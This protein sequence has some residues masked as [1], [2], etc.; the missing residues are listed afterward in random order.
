MIILHLTRI[1]ILCTVAKCLI[2]SVKESKTA[3]LSE[4]SDGRK[5]HKTRTKILNN[6][7][8]TRI[9]K[10]TQNVNRKAYQ[11]DEMENT[12]TQTHA[13][14]RSRLIMK[15]EI[16]IFLFFLFFLRC[17]RSTRCCCC[18]CCCCCHQIEYFVE[19]FF[20]S[21]SRCCGRVYAHFCLHLRQQYYIIFVSLLFVMCLLRSTHHN[22]SQSHKATRSQ[23]TQKKMLQNVCNI[24]DI[25]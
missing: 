16:S 17:S 20:H 25:N 24:P 13:P 22:K 3:Q 2:V 4:S 11:I 12:R 5:K 9:R 15:R 23:S 8:T 6:N 19:L 14:T 18:R 21:F 7:S 10:N 1:T